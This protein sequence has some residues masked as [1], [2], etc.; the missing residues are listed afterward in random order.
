M[1]ESRRFNL[2]S[3]YDVIAEQFSP[4]LWDSF[5]VAAH[6]STCGNH[7]GSALRSA[8]HLP[9]RQRPELRLWRLA[10]R[11]LWQPPPHQKSQPLKVTACLM[12][13]KLLL[14]VTFSNI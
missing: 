1:R 2:K 7:D 6:L 8:L 4:E 12:F 5:K 14:F 10:R 3:E 11:M 13:Q 9:R